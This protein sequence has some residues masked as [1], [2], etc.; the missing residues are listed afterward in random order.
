MVNIFDIKNQIGIYNDT[1][2]ADFTIEELQARR[3]QQPELVNTL[4][5]YFRNPT[6]YSQPRTVELGASIYF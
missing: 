4:G 1:G 5:E 6:F 3:N 2:R